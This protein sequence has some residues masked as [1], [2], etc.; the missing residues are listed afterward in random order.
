M[1]VAL[2]GGSFDP[3]HRSHR[4]LVE[5]AIARLRPARVL[6]VPCAQN[7][8]KPSSTIASAADRLAMCELA[9]R[10]LSGVAVSPLEIER[11]APSYT[12]DTVR[13]LRAQLG[14]DEPLWLLC[15]SDVLPELDRWHEQHSLLELVTLVVFPRLGAPLDARVLDR[16]A[17][18]RKHKDE[19]LANALR[20][21]PDAVSATAIRAALARG[22]S[23]TE[24]MPEVLAYV[25]SHGLYRASSGVA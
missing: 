18:R 14:L 9:F 13:A 23:P 20:I 12:I 16:L 19:I 10:G 2:F 17:I 15:G 8:L 3:P 5:A 11:R 7:P 21:E 6:I 22:E 24:L 4:R 1:R 25:R